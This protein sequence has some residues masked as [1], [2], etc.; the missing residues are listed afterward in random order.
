MSSLSQILSW[1]DS[2]VD[3]NRSK[4]PHAFNWVRCLPFVAMHLACLLALVTGAS[5]FAI[6][7]CLGFFWL[8]MF[9][10]T[11]FYHRYFSHRS[12]QTSRPWQFVFAVLGNMSAQRGPLWWAAHHRHHHQHSDQK[13]DLHSPLQR[14]FWWSHV[15]WFTCDASFQTQTHRIKDF[16]KYPELRFINRY[17]MLVPIITGLLIFGLGETLA[18]LAPALETN[19]FQ[20]LV[21]GF[22]ISTIVL[23][24]STVTINSLAHCWGSRRF[25]TKDNSRN[26]FI[27]A[28]L[29][30]GEGWHNNHH[31]WPRSAKQGFYWWEIDITY[32]ILK[33]MAAVGIIHSLSP[34]P[35]KIYQ[36]VNRQTNLLANQR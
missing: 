21:W 29:T 1:F 28:L 16:Y 3:L 9:A 4:D 25:N 26:N 27:L 12:F 24:H 34:V 13:Q 23:F 2:E 19:G 10:I 14:G 31:R 33:A 22:F 18:V 8:R 20:L 11:A 5:T 15:G 7:F 30:L 36:E 32:Y 6:L 17:D 35:E